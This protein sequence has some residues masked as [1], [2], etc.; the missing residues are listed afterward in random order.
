MHASVVSVS[1]SPTHS[2]SKA[3]APEITL[4]AG[5]GVAGD[6]HAGVT[7]RHRYRVRQD[8]TAPNLCQVHLLHSEL[9][10]ELAL[11]GLVVTPGQMGENITTAGIDLLGL[12]RHTRLHL[13]AS[14]IIEITGLRDPC[15]QM[16]GLK[17]G[18]MKA[19]IAR[20]ANGEIVRKAGIMGIVIAG[21]TVR[22]GDAIEVRLPPGDLLPL[23]PV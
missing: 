17:P 19:C 14:S 2:F 4:L 15:N 23:Y 21:G 13:G 8:P 3:A 7:V 12:P 11:Q 6:A 1:L 18:L 20:A 16:N 9:F 5:L 22:A 10:A